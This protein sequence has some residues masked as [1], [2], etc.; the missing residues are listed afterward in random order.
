M[1][2]DTTATLLLA[3]AV[4]A[5]IGD[6]GWL[7]R[8]VPHPVA[9]VGRLVGRLDRAWNRE[10]AGE[11]ARRVLGAVALAAVVVAAAGAGWLV[12]AGLARVPFGWLAEALLMS[13]L[14]AQHGLYRH[15]RAVA[16]ALETD[17]LE[18][19]RKAVAHVVGRDPDRLDAAGVSRAALESL[20]EN[21]S[22]GVTAPLFWGLVG[23]LPGMLAYK[24]IN[25]ADSMI[26]HL[27]PRHAAFGWAAAR[28]DDLVNLIPAR[29]A[30]CLLAAAARLMPGGDARA[31][32]VALRRD[33]PRHRSP[34][35]GWPEAAIAGA[36]G[37]ALN[38]PRIYGGEVVD[39]P[40]MNHGARAEAGPAD[41]RRGLRL[42]I[43]ACTMQAMIV[44]LIALL[45]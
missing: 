36:L 33:A 24:A 15:V 40:W 31:A 7:Y 41:I 19:G 6:P 11:T 25:T 20:A 5:A 43:L 44:G 10:S 9:V 32:F 29:V 16:T 37:L 23:G 14:L 12:H 3:I 17:G 45:A 42:Y 30:G 34:N 18:A 28:T 22:D 39:G 8:A 35:A 2:L 1:H 27:S 4:D 21:F 38:G 13:T 26:G